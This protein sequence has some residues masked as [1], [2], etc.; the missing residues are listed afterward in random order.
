MEKA[1]QDSL[2]TSKNGIEVVNHLQ[3]CKKAARQGD[4]EAKL[5]LLNYPAQGQVLHMKSQALMYAS[6]VVAS[7][8][9]PLQELFKIHIQHLTSL[10][11]LK[12]QETI[13]E[14]QRQYQEQ[15]ELKK[16]NKTDW[17]KVA[18][19]DSKLD[20]IRAAYDLAY[21]SLEGYAKCAGKDAIEDFLPILNNPKYPLRMRAKAVKL[22]SRL[23]NQTLDRGLPSEPGDWHAEDLPLGKIDEWLLAGKPDGSGYPVLSRDSALD[24]PQTRLEKLCAQ[25]DSK[26][27]QR[28]LDNFDSAH[29]SNILVPANSDL[30]ASLAKRDLLP[31][32]YLEFLARFSPV[33]VMLHD[34]KS[35]K[36][37]YLYGFAAHLPKNERSESDEPPLPD[38]HFAIARLDDKFYVLHLDESTGIDAPVYLA[39]HKS[40][41]VPKW[42]A[43][44]VCDSFLDFLEQVVLR[45]NWE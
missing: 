43:K 25:L 26:L 6:Q 44:K 7:E 9:S 31:S 41:K 4:L 27:L 34:H 11:F 45:K 29:P 23:S 42:N 33:Q 17:S 39:S 2:Y 16:Y 22:I 40:S 30:L 15:M 3:S 5:T 1:T 37:L 14:I 21:H 28:R 32:I 19:L 8:D 36:C 20:G 13:G 24:A 10:P 35:L 18:Y 38:S 12:E